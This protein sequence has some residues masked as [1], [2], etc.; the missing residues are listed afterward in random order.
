MMAGAPAPPELAPTATRAS[1]VGMTTKWSIVPTN[2][3]T[4]ELTG[5]PYVKNSS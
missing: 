3:K 1:D 5:T 4:T 2:H